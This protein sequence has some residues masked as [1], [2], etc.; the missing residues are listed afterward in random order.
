S[1]PA[2]GIELAD[3]SAGPPLVALAGIIVAGALAV[4]GMRGSILAGIATTLVLGLAFGVLDGPDGVADVPGSDSFSTIG[5]ALSWDHIEEA[6][7]LVL[8]P[9]IFALF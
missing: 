6:L 7:S 4:R 1:S 5:D 8:I 3:L 9:V 2:T